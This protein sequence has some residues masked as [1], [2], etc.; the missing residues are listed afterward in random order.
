MTNPAPTVYDRIGG[1]EAIEA[2]V[3]DFY[4]RVLTDERLAGFFTGTNMSRLKGRQAEFFAAA[5]GGPVTYT[6]RGMKE[7]HEGMDIGDEHFERVA[8]HLGEAL[9]KAGVPEGTADEII[10][11][12]APLSGDIV[13]RAGGSAS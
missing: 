3:D 5:L 6:G 9:L 4:V 10:A 12:V 2:V 8:L 11:A 1:Y 7:V 13:T